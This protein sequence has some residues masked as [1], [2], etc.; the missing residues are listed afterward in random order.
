M[1]KQLQ[2]GF[3]LIELMIV[4][5]IIGILAAIAIPAYQDYTIRAQVSEGLSLAD[6]AKTALAEYY[7]NTGAFPPNNLLVWLHPPAL[8]VITLQALMFRKLLVK[9][10]LPMVIK[11]TLQLKTLFWLFQPR[12]ALV[13]FS[14]PARAL[15]LCHKNTC[16]L[17]A[18]APKERTGSSSYPPS[19]FTPKPA[20]RRVF[21]WRRKCLDASVRDPGAPEFD[22]LSQ[23]LAENADPAL[24]EQRVS[25]VFGKVRV[26]ARF[27]TL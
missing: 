7:T 11:P 3:T 5:A 4:V 6:G 27:S 16:L 20:A 13:Q 22:S 26:V 8:P 12:Q 19:F 1:K 25:L 9:F 21:S 24:T 2:Q 10:K 18:R 15:H 23:K 14:G 17:R